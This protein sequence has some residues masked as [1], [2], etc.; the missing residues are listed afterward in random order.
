[1]MVRTGSLLVTAALALVGAGC[2]K[3]SEDDCKKAVAHIRKLHGTDRED[4]SVE[5]AAI[6]SCR[7]NASKET[8]KCINNA[9]DVAALRACEGDLYEKM[10]GDEPVETDKPAAPAPAPA[11]PPSPTAPAPPAGTAPAVPP[12]APAAPTAPT[13]PPAQ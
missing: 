4:P 10:F 8:V 13:T 7:G 6:R 3:P 1:M 11:A 9:Q 2:D 5:R 12:A